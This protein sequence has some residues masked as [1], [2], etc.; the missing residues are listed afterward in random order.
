MKS[1]GAIDERAPIVG[2]RVGLPVERGAVDGDGDDGS[3]QNPNQGGTN[4]RDS[5]PHAGRCAVQNRDGYCGERRWNEQGGDDDAQFQSQG[6]AEADLC[7][8]FEA[9][10]GRTEC[11][12]RDELGARQHPGEE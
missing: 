11:G 6:L 12:V 7:G 3:G 8:F 9:F 2:R 1:F 5:E 10:D 4:A